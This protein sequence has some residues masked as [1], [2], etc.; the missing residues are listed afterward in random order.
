MFDLVSP[1]ATNDGL[2]AE[3]L[4]APIPA[5]RPSRISMKSSIRQVGLWFATGCLIALSGPTLSANEPPRQPTGMGGEPIK[6][7]PLA[8]YQQELLTLAFDVASAIPVRPHIKDRSRTQA[9]V[10]DACF[11]LNQPE[12][13]LGFIE[14]IG[15]WRRGAG[16][17]D[18]AL[19]AAKLGDRGAAA[20]HIEIARQVAAQ[21]EDWRRDHINVA[22]ASVHAWLGQMSRADQLAAEAQD[23]ESARLTAVKVAIGDDE[24]FESQMTELEAV[25]AGES[26]DLLVHAL[27]AYVKL[28]DRHFGHDV[29]RERIERRIRESSRKLPAPF[30]IELLMSMSAI[31]VEHGHLAKALAVVDE[32]RCV[33]DGHAWPLPNRISL[34]A[35][36]AGRR[37]AAGGIDAART[38]LN[39][40]IALYDAERASI[41]DID[42]ASVLRAVAES[43]RQIND[44]ERSLA[45]YKRAI[46]EGVQNPNSRPRAEDLCA[47]C[48]SM[49]LSGVEPDE[50]LWVRL[51]AIRAALEAPW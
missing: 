16:H 12:T 15:N 25:T 23:S 14:R 17:A 33:L 44:G 5:I 30:R 31:A 46:E 27:N 29:R 37:H 40:A 1:R 7:A 41:V 20:R 2:G 11:Q 18:Y 47:T 10:V 50:A 3:E 49:A 22:I 48:I 4:S 28:F 39:E 21:E 34:I 32:G 35:R 24:S 26:Y 38:E 42:R 9:S 13:A 43:L 6:N 8:P 51:R 19:H 36:L 45:A